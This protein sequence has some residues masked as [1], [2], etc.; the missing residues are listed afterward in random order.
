MTLEHDLGDGEMVTLSTRRREPEVEE[1]FNIV[2]G[3]I[4]GVTIAGTNPQ[5]TVGYVGRL[6]RVT[7]HV[8]DRGF[9]LDSIELR[10]GYIRGDS[11]TLTP[12]D[13]EELSLRNERVTAFGFMDEDEFRVRRERAVYENNRRREE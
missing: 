4:Y 3:N 11:T 5:I 6:Q 8:C 9:V 1:R 10:N 2:P 12:F 13:R 7:M